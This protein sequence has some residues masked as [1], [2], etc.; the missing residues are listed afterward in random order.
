VAALS[1]KELI[2]KDFVSEP[3]ENSLRTAGDAM[4]KSLAGNLALVTSKEPVRNSLLEAVHGEL[5]HL[6]MPAVSLSFT[7]TL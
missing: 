1:S 3:D 5:I 2:C 4:V 7:R 6:G